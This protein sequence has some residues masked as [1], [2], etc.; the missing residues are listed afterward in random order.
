MEA[1]LHVE[2]LKLTGMIA[3][4]CISRTHSQMK[5]GLLLACCKN[6]DGNKLCLIRGLEF[7]SSPQGDP[8][9]NECDCPLLMMTHIIFTTKSSAIVN[10]VSIIHECGDTCKFVTKQW[11]KNIEREK[12]YLSS[13][14]EYEHDF[15]NSMYYLNIYCT[16]S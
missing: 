16:N 6:S 3:D 14:I 2:I 5:Y 15:G 8:I 10:A 4:I 11:P 7:L 12:L 13:Q 1:E 9:T